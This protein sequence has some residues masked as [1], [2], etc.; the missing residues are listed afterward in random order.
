MSASISCR[1]SARRTRCSASPAA[2]SPSTEP[3]LPW[4]STSGWRSEKSCAMRTGVVDR[5]VA[6]RVVLAD[7]VADDARRLLYGRFQS[8][9]SS[10]IANSTRRCTGLRPSRGVGQGRP[11]DHA[12]R[13]VEVRAPHFLFE[14]DRQGFFGE[15]GHA[16]GDAAQ[17]G[18]KAWR[19]ATGLRPRDSNWSASNVA[20]AQ[21]ACL[22]RRCHPKI[23]DHPAPYGTMR[24]RWCALQPRLG[25]ITRS[26]V[27]TIAGTLRLFWR[28]EP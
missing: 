1:S 7:H 12:H 8:L 14:A 24:R 16:R 10:C 26:P 22:A 21:Q 18:Y 27:R 3:K 23:R 2:L 20:L 9:L 15:L 25:P 11:D 6:V 4:P 28:G 19:S 17:D 5:L 13:V